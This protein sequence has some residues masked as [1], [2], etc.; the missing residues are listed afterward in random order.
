MC[1]VS[2]CVCVSVSVCV[3]TVHHNPVRGLVSE[4]QRLKNNP[5]NRCTSVRSY[6]VCDSKLII[7]VE[8]LCGYELMD[9]I[10]QQPDFVVILSPI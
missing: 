8:E 1:C 3:N 4:E 10:V 6:C 5:M 7:I 9:R 2:A